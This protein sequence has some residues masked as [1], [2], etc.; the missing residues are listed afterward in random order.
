[1]KPTHKAKDL[2]GNWVEGYY[3]NYGDPDLGIIVINSSH[4]LVNPSTLCQRVRGTDFFEG[5]EV[6]RVD[7]PMVGYLKFDYKNCHWYISGYGW[8]ATIEELGLDNL[9][10]TGKNIHDNEQ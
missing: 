2:N 9:K 10:P 1:M 5:D 4:I 6:R 3:V 8:S 7:Y